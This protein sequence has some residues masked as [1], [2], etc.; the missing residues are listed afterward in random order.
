MEFFRLSIKI[1]FLSLLLVV[2]KTSPADFLIAA[3]RIES[4]LNEVIDAFFRHFLTCELAFWR[5]LIVKRHDKLFLLST[6]GEFAEENAKWIEEF[7]LSTE[8]WL[9]AETHLLDCNHELIVPIAQERDE[10]LPARAVSQ[11]LVL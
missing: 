1:F 2:S 10:L 11:K 4:V 9:D 5:H 3:L 8:V 6:D 7:A